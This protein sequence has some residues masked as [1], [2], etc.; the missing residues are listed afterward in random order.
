MVGETKACPDWSESD[1]PAMLTLT[2]QVHLMPSHS[3]AHLSR[4]QHE[5]D[6]VVY[7]YHQGFLGSQNE[8]TAQLRSPSGF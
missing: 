6:V 2:L 5:L 4:A 7:L 1:C 8:H 3:R